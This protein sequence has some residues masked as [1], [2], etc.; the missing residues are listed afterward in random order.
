[1]KK[2]RLLIALAVAALW[3]APAFADEAA[4]KEGRALFAQGTQQ[5]AADD[6]VGALDL[7]Q[8]AYARFPNPKILL[9]IGTTQR[10][11]GRN[12]EAANTYVAYLKDPGADP[13]RKA[14]VERLLADLDA[15]L[16]KLKIA[17]SDPAMRARVD[18]K[19]VGEPGQAITIRVEP[20]SH[21]ILG[22]QQGVAPAVATVTVAAREEQS[23]TLGAAP[24]VAN[25]APPRAK[26][27]VPVT[28]A[29]GQVPPAKPPEP[30]R[31]VPPAASDKSKDKVVPLPATLS[32]RWQLGAIARADI[33]GLG[34]GVVPALGLSYGIGDHLEVQ[35]CALVGRDKGFEPSM[36]L[37]FLRGAWKPL[38]SVGVPIFFVDGARPGIHGDA[39]VQW[40]PLHH[41]GVFAQVGGAFFPSVPVGYNKLV[42]VPSVGVQA[43]L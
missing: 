26:A 5:L 20:G 2:P 22:E 27:V 6:L 23:V 32:H 39:G 10:N 43:R 29:R 41:F 38:V 31:V 11:L 3:S 33:Q 8:R 25:V 14:E 7:F 17:L 36:E 40:D 42:F 21:T 28:P 34:R 4:E 9:N 37:F 19:V 24:A 12:A 35:A 13:A 30:S 18:G 16:G 1:M 15:R